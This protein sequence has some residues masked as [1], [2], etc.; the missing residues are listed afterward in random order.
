VYILVA[1]DAEGILDLHG[2]VTG[3]VGVVLD[4]QSGGSSEEIAKRRTTDAERK[5]FLKVFKEN[6]KS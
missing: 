6:I 2:T 3:S 4:K 1:G 5:H